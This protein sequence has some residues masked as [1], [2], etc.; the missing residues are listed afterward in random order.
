MMGFCWE[1]IEEYGLLFVDGVLMMIKCIIICVIFGMLWGLIFGFG[2]MVKVEYGLW[3][4]I[5]CY[6]V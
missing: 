2:W 1:I 4:Y 5:F 3:K 6:L